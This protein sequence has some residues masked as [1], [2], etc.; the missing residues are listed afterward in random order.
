MNRAALVLVASLGGCH[1]GG[2]SSPKQQAVRP[3]R[4]VPVAGAPPT[5]VAP[6]PRNLPGPISVNTPLTAEEAV[7]AMPPHGAKNLVPAVATTN[8]R[9]VRT[10]ECID[11]K[12]LAS[13]TDEVVYSLKSGGWDPV[14]VRPGDKLAIAA[15][16]D[17]LRLAY[18]VEAVAG[19]TGCDATMG[20]FVATA[21]LARVAAPPTLPP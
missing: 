14:T 12:D 13:A 18:T 15:A 11:G 3:E 8:D 16:K 10:V 2:D 17:D 6:P 1:C 19:R 5:R 4:N 20:E 7:A 21:T 9:A